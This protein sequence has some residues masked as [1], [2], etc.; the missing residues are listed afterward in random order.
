MDLNGYI[1]METGIDLSQGKLQK[2]MRY[3]LLERDY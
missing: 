1:Q 3:D 2:V